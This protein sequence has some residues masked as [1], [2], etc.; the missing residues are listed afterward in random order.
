MIKRI[1]YVACLCESA[2]TV[3]AY[4][5]KARVTLMPA[6]PLRARTTVE[7]SAFSW[8]E[9]QNTQK[10]TRT[11]EQ[12]LFLRF[13][14]HDSRHG[15]RHPS[16]ITIN[17]QTLNRLQLRQDQRLATHNSRNFIEISCFFGVEVF[18][19]RHLLIIRTFCW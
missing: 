10:E 3:A 1:C 6:E 2:H 13:I 14:R 4:G 12:T 16:T 8:E 15:T 19:L 7:L 17:N 18:L 9:A 11:K 5:G